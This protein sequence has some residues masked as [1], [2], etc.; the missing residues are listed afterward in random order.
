MSGTDPTSADIQLHMSIRLDEKKIVLNSL[1][2][3]TWGK[4][5]RKSNPY[6][7]EG[8]PFDI[9]IRAHDKKFEVS[10]FCKLKL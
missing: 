7:K 8:E 3:G 1:Q 4:E 10:S 5:D 9:R 6:T 2:G